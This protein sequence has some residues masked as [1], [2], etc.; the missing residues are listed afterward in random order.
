MGRQPEPP[1]ADAGRQH[2]QMA[3]WG[4]VAQLRLNQ[5][6]SGTKGGMESFEADLSAV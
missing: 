1:P 3:P 4:I 5:Q 2:H 6:C